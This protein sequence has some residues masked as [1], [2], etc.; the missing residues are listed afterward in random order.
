VPPP[1]PPNLLANGSFDHAYLQPGL[2]PWTCEPGARAVRLDPDLPNDFQLAGTPT[3]RSTA[4]CWQTVP[5]RPGSRYELTG[6]FKGGPAE[7]GTDYSSTATSGSAGWST[8]S[9][10]FTTGPDT[11]RIR[12]YVHGESAQSTFYADAVTLNGPDSTVVAP[13]APVHL[14]AVEQRSRSVDLRWV[15]SPG[16]TYY[17][18][19]QD[20]TQIGTTGSLS[21]TS[22]LARG[23]TPGSTHTYTVAA[24][25]AAGTSPAARPV[26]STAARAYDTPPPPPTAI[27]A[28]V[29]GRTAFLSWNAVPTATDGYTVLFVEMN[30]NVPVFANH[31][32]TRLPASGT[33]TVTVSSWNSAG[34]GPESAPVTLTVP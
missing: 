7:F 32:T 12:V 27:K 5:V 10:S 3:A 29:T 15:G 19:Y 16:A 26:T 28:S 11:S 18:V 2:A 1:P 33:Y 22:Y 21:W 13:I 23:L 20:G 4:G 6:R 34:R 30:N 8:L 25:N 9:L 24:A 14:Q 17:L 31:F